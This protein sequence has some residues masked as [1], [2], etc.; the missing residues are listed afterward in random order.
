MQYVECF[1]WSGQQVARCE[2]GEHRGG[3]TRGA[4][5]SQVPEAEALPTP[6]TEALP[7]L[8]ASQ[9][10]RKIQLLFSKTMALH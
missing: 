2:H 3:E 4:E 9:D 8:F 1:K 7:I 10:L 6:E 5:C